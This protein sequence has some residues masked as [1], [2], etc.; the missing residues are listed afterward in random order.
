MKRAL[1]LCF[2]LLSCGEVESEAPP[3]KEPA[4]AK[5]VQAPAQPPAK[6]VP[7]PAGAPA[8]GQGAA[9]IVRT[10]YAL[11]EAG[12]YGEARRL[13]EKP[14]GTDPAAF[15]ANFE[16]YAEHR[17]TVG[18]PSEVVEGGD[19]LYVEVPVQTYGRLRSGNTFG[20]AGTVS[21]RRRKGEP[22]AGWRIYTSG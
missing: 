18:T 13:R 4:P 12:D 2:A 11:I 8:A 5:P 3:T 21:L 1:L 6:P 10:Y 14:A 15:A 19:W 9:E 22:N 20:S 7:E 17:A 16:R